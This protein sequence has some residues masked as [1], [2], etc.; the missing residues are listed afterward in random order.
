MNEFVW[1]SVTVTCATCLHKWKRGLLRRLKMSGAKSSYVIG[2][3]WCFLTFSVKWNP[4]QQLW[5]LTE[6]M[7]F[8]GTP[9]VESRGRGSWAVSSL[10]RQLRGLGQC[11]KLPQRGLG[12]IPDH[13]YILDL[14]RAEKMHLVAANVGHSLVFLLSTGGPAEPLDT[15]GGTLMFHRTPVENTGICYSVCPV[16][17][18]VSL[19]F[20]SMAECVFFPEYLQP[21]CWL[22]I[23]LQVVIL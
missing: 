1:L 13:K 17:L 22:L 15:T 10:P 12:Q 6:P 14:V 7:C 16:K 3:C 19:V 11:G 9:E 23:F 2:I 5:L 4:L 21:F 20:C 18:S 8:G